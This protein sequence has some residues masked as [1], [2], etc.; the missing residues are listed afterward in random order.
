MTHGCCFWQR[1]CKLILRLVQWSVRIKANF[2]FLERISFFR[3]TCCS[4]LS[5][6]AWSGESPGMLKEE[7]APVFLILWLIINTE[8]SYEAAAHSS[9]SQFT[10]NMSASSSVATAVGSVVVVTHVIPAP[11]V[12][13][14]QNYAAKN[15]FSQARPEALGVRNWI[16]SSYCRY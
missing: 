7:A 10:S 13:A 15:K 9:S 1:H 2:I 11:Q 14:P 12:G 8:L 6:L 16:W 3:H 4:D 5:Q